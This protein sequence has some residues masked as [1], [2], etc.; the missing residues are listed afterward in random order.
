MIKNINNDYPY[1]NNH[2]LNTNDVI[3]IHHKLLIN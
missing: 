1:Y 2:C 3:N